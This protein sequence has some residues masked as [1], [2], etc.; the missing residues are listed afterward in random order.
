M[1]I[2][3]YPEG[4]YDWESQLFHY[5][6]SIVIDVLLHCDTDNPVNEIQKRYRKTYPH[7]AYLSIASLSK[8]VEK[9]KAQGITEVIFLIPPGKGK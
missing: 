2:I 8:Y 1:D 7:Y 6:K 3:L 5:Y 9:V 4:I